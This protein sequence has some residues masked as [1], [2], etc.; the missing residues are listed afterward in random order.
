V[1][2]FPKDRDLTRPPREVELR[3]DASFLRMRS[4]EVEIRL[5][6]FLMQ[7][8][9]WRSRTSIQELIKTDHVLVDPSTPDH[10]QGSGELKVERRSGRRL[11]DGSRVVVII[12]A[13][14]RLPE[15]VETKDELTILYEDEGVLGVEKPP[16]VAVHPSG[17][18]LAD[19]LIQRVH[20]R[21]GGDEAL[22][23]GGAPRLCHRLDRETSGVVI[24]GKHPEAHLAVMRQF[25]AR[26]VGKEYLALVH[27]APDA[28]NGVVELPIGP[29]RASRIGL[30]MAVTFDGQPSRTDWSVVMRHPHCTLVSCTPVTGRQHQIRLHME[31]I[32]LPL[33]G[34]KLYG[35]DDTLF[36]KGVDGTLTADDYKLLGMTRHALH[37]HR[38][39]L[40]SPATGEMVD[41]ISPL[42]ED[43]QAFVDGGSAGR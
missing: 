21:Y 2:L 38:V 14:L 18:H 10:R 43:M 32:G 22:E 35:P 30:K 25:E 17:R 9:K 4:D 37:N 24:V 42:A 5:D 8:L 33:V 36:Q 20:A 6:H 11:R 27:G 7:H 39:T 13:E 15:P 12:P 26:K 31:A 34:D 16:M 40:R 28:D 3:V 19:T 1:S 41:V 23:T 29:A